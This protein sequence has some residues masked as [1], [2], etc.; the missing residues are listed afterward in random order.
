MIF[1]LIYKIMP[2]VHIQWH[3]VWIGAAVTALLFT[4]GKFLIGLYIGRSGIASGFGAAASLVVLLLWVYYSAQ[5]F[6]LGAEFTWAYAH[7][8]GSMK[9]MPTAPAEAPLAPQ[10]PV[11]LV[12]R[13][14]PTGSPARAPAIA[15]R[16]ESVPMTLLG[17]D[18]LHGVMIAAAA[19]FVL[20][21]IGGRVVG[22]ALRKARRGVRKVADWREGR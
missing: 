12:A 20:Q 9:G 10:P 18:P 4:I 7:A 17:R 11:P 2:R 6:L 16:P 19:G 13:T 1:A 14:R 21:L 3:D 15:P 8:F 5:I 22:S